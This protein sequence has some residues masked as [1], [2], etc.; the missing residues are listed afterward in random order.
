MNKVMHLK[1]LLAKADDLE[2]R[3]GLFALLALGVTESVAHG[4]MTPQA[5][6]RVF[7]NAENCL[8][9]HSR[10]HNKTADR[11]MSHGVQ[12]QDLFDL[13]S[14]REAH[15]ELKRELTTIRNLC[16]KLFDKK[17]LVA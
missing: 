13:L 8:F 12:L 16:L 1:E 11:I 5:A 3:L 2:N 17:Q 9:V 10:L 7:F 15:R 14:A 4:S 6:I